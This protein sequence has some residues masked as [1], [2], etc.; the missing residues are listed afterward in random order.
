MD[1]ITGTGRIIPHRERRSHVQSHTASNA[2]NRVDGD[3]GARSWEGEVVSQAE[4]NDGGRDKLG[5]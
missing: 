2:T 1:I 4:L 3:E 5:R